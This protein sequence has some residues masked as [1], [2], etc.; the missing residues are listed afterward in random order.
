MLFCLFLIFNYV[1]LHALA[2]SVFCIASLFLRLGKIYAKIRFGAV[3][4]SIILRKIVFKNPYN[5]P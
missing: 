1:F 4:P 5:L 2:N 3:C